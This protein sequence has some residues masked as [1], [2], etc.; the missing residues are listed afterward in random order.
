M[1]R[2]NAEASSWCQILR[3]IFSL[4]AFTAEENKGEQKKCKEKQHFLS[5][6]WK[7]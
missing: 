5:D 4:N 2:Q 1:P 6:E 3:I 7:R